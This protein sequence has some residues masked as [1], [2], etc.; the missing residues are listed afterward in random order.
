[1]G[2][3]WATTTNLSE[4]ENLGPKLH[5]TKIPRCFILKV[6]CLRT[7]LFDF[8]PES[9][10][11]R[12]EPADATRQG[13]YVPEGIYWNWESGIRDHQGDVNTMRMF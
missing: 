1:M 10:W 3:A 7:G 5:C 12:L 6:N 11:E 9:R 4:M 13:D 8:T 2:P